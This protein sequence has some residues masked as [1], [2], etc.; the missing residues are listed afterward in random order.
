MRVEIRR[1]RYFVRVV[2]LKSLSRAADEMNLAQ[3]ALGMQI[4]KLEDE[5]QTHLLVRHS[6]GVEPTE[7]GQLLRQYANDIL[8]RIEDAKQAVRELSGPLRGS[9]RLAT[10]PSTPPYVTIGLIQLSAVQLPNIKIKFQEA[11]NAT[12]L[13]WVRA[14]EVDF[15]LAHLSDVRLDGLI[16]EPLVQ[17]S[18]VFVQAAD[19]PLPPTISLSEVCCHPLVMPAR[20]HHLRELLHS[21]AEQAGHE[22]DVAFEIGSIGTIMELVERNIACTVLPR[23]AVQRYLNDGRVVARTVTDPGLRLT[24]SLVRSRRRALTRAQVTLRG[25]ISDLVASEPARGDA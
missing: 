20:P 10:T 23:G 7:A 15:G 19:R 14:E 22:P 9:V 11:M 25:L 5:L 17:E 4:R 16:V 12:M 1:L 13:D 24:V 8:Q 3:P 2:D 6:R 18:A 21:T